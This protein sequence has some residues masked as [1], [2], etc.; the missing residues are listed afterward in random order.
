MNNYTEFVNKWIEDET[1]RTVEYYKKLKEDFMK[2]E[3][4]KHSISWREFHYY[5]ETVRNNPDYT[6]EQKQ[7]ILDIIREYDEFVQ[8]KKMAIEFVTYHNID[9]EIPTIR[10]EVKKHF[11]KLQAK[12]EKKIGKILEIYHQ[13]GDDYHFIGEN[14]N[15]SVE[16]IL[17]GGYNI[18]RLHTRWIITK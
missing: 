10:K 8:G 1:Q 4:K 18:Q 11:E 14:G 5:Y 13:G 17:A 9:K 3:E 7:H 15:C 6:E 2:I 16:V 12:V